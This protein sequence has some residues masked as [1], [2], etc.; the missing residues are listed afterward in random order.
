M[1]RGPRLDQRLVELGLA[2]SRER[3]RA[4]ILAG[5]VRIDGERADKAGRA[6]PE[7]AG[8]ILVAPDHPYVSRGGV[9]LEGALD[10]L[11]VD[12]QGLVVLDVGIST[13]GFT[14][15]LLQRGA[16]RAFGVDVGYGQVALKLRNDERVTLF[17]RTN[18]RHFDPARVDE[19]LDLAVIDASFIA[20]AKLLPKLAECLAPGAECLALVKPQF[21]LSKA[22][23]GKG[24]VVR[25]DGLREEA[26]ARASEAA[27]RCGFEVLGS[28]DSRLHGPKG[29]REI[30]L[31]LRRV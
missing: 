27:E 5:K 30:F 24:G 17:E 23:V 28:A 9:K 22:E 8:V 26:V 18:F 19:T 12:P 14:D 13:G 25:D 10:D 7:G 4:L 2:P 20:L 3:A 16:R 11:G 21:E 6:V 1:A 31:Y 29:N 15:C